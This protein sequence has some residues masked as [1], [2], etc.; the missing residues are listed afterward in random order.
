MKIVITPRGFARSGRDFVKIM[1]SNGFTVDLNDSG[2]QYTREEFLEHCK[3]A[4]GLIVGIEQVDREF[5]EKCPQIKAVVKFGVGIDNIDLEACRESGVYAD[6][7]AGSNSRSVAEHAMAMIMAASKNIYDCISETRNQNWK[8]FTNFEL[9]GKTLGI[10]GFGAIGR[11]LSEMANGMGMKVLAY[12]TFPV[13]A[14]EAGKH[15]AVMSDLDSIY[16]ESDLISLHVPLTVETRNMISMEQLRKM[17]ESCILI[18]TARGGIVNEDDLLEALESGAIRS[19]W[20]DVYS[21][22]P[23]AEWEG[24]LKCDKFYITPHIAASTRE[25]DINCCR[26]S[27]EKIIAALGGKQ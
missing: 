22:E 26:M 18:N 2:K 3:D 5:L 21:K 1:E 9:Y 10:I 25:A 4:D 7:C 20:F 6:R 27:T 11:L 13:S 14:E 15:G 19:A 12:D 8:K 16:S 23:P 24:L 17:K